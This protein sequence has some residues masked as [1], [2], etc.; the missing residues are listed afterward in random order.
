[1]LNHGAVT[2]RVT[3]CE[4]SVSTSLTAVGFTVDFLAIFHRLRYN[5]VQECIIY[6]SE[7]CCMGSKAPCV[8]QEIVLR[9]S[10]EHVIRALIRAP[11]ER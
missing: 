4:F 10:E 8:L 9:I 6:F 5:P 1:M 3:A 11:D 7:Q 2:R